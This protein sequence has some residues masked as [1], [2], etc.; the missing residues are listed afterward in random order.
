MPKRCAAGEMGRERLRYI[1][2]EKKTSEKAKEQLAKILITR[3]M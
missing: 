1:N 3:Q 2:K